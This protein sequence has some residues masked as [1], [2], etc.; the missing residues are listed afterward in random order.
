[1]GKVIL[2]TGAPGTGK[3]TLRK[4]LGERIALLEHF[5]YGQLLLRRRELVAPRISYEQLREQS[6]AIISPEDVASTDAWVISEISRL[7]A[8]SHILIDSHALTRES[9]GFRA[10][11]FSMQQLE[12]LR[13][14]ALVVLRCDP[15]EL[16][17]RV[18]RDPGGRRSLTREL[19]REIQMLQEALALTYGVICGCP[20]FVIDST[21]VGIEEV[22][23]RALR[24]LAQIGI[25]A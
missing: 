20:V 13:L 3:S 7:R 1:L 17:A 19:A 8:K 5:D 11:A 12:A 10:V 16:I 21:N 15:E 4:I 6:A 24:V 2:L 9:Y 18:A 22:A 14:D 23:N 25:N